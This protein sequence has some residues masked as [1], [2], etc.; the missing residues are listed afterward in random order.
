[1]SDPTLPH[2]K[3]IGTALGIECEASVTEV[4]IQPEDGEETG[5]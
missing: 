4:E 5:E 2:L 3:R 1:M